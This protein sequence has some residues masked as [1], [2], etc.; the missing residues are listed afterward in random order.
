MGEGD[1]LTVELLDVAHHLHLAVVA[2]EHLM[3]EVV[4]G[5]LQS[6]WQLHRRLYVCDGLTAVLCSRRE[7]LQQ[8]IHSLH[9][10]S[11]IDADAY[12]PVV[13]IVQVHLLAQGDG[14]YLLDTYASWKLYAECIKV[15]CVLLAVAIG[16]Q[17]FV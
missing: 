16:S 11:L 10:G 12:A 6:L 8:R 13:Q 4:A 15:G 5:A 2:L 3:G 9:I 7:Y 14:F 17:S 1:V